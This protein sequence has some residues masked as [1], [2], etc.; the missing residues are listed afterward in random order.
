MPESGEDGRGRDALPVDSGI[1]RDVNAR[2]LLG[3]LRDH[4]PAT[5]PELVRRTGLARPTVAAIVRDLL[6]RGA[7]VDAGVDR[8]ATGRPAMLLAFDPRWATV[9]VCRV[10][11]H[12][13]DVVV[14]DSAGTELGRLQREHPGSVGPG[15]DVL[16]EMITSLSAGLRVPRPA[17]ATVLLGARVDPTTG[18]GAAAAFGG[19]APVTVGELA[20]RLALP[21]VVLNPAASAALGVARGGR[22]RDAVVVFLDHGIGL[23]IVSAGRV[24]T[25]ASGG[26]GELG[27]CRLPGR[28]QVCACGRVGCLETVSAGWAIRRRVSGL[29]RRPDDH[30]TLVE[31]EG[32]GDERVDAVLDE[33]AW[34]LGVAGSWVVNLLDPTTVLLGGSPFAAGASRFLATFATAVRENSVADNVSDLRIDFAGD[35]ADVEGA[36]CAALDLL[37]F[38]S[39]G[40][41]VAR[42]RPDR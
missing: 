12:V 27:H 35:R 38:G 3:V 25:G 34:H 17:A 29:L 30:A 13:L 24:L 1:V 22:H 16:A 39:P 18:A 19:G 4:G 23:G 28:D 21:V 36:V 37:P 26:T 11:P 5:Q 14:A 10:L 42:I 7:V 20:E 6:A 32:L 40:A 15:L 8:G 33:A 2:R 41:P 9:A 31:L